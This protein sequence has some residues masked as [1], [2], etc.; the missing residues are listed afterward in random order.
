LPIALLPEV[1]GSMTNNYAQRQV[2]MVAQRSPGETK[3]GWR[4]LRVLGNLM[5]FDGFDYEDINDVM[6]KTERY[7]AEPAI[8]HQDCKVLQP[9][10]KGLALYPHQGIY[11]GDQ[12]VRRSQPLQ[13]SVLATSDTVCVN[14][15]DLLSIGFNEGDLVSVEQGGRYAELTLSVSDQVPEGS[16]VV[17]MGRSSSLNIDAGDLSV[18]IIGAQS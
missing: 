6:S 10:V 8:I 2:T 16:A 17:N 18:G 9:A 4:V 15:S 13:D 1:T 7:Q 14:P 5:G 3:P 12:L 11:D